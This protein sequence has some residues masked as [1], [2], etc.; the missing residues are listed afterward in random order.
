[1]CIVSTY[2]LVVHK[3]LELKIS[4]HYFLINFFYILVQFVCR[5]GS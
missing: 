1:M 5:S 2:I 4:N 3:H